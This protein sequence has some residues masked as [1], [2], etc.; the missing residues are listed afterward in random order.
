MIQKNTFTKKDLKHRLTAFI[1]PDLVKRAKVRGALEGLT[2]SQIVEKAL[3]AYAP[4]LEKGKDK[5]INVRFSTYHAINAPISEISMKQI[6][7]V[8]KHTKALVVPR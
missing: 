1:E 7:M 8:P 4:K 6:E 5:Q 2:I 3:D